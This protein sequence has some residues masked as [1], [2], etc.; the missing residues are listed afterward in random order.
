MRHV[1]FKYHKKLG[2][3]LKSHYQ[4]YEVAFPKFMHVYWWYLSK[5][6]H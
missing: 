3:A 2:I 1:I 6:K 4:Y 5:K